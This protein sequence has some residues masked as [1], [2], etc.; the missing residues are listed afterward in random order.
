MVM[1][2][3]ASFVTTEIIS[4]VP[5]DLEIIMDMIDKLYVK[6][7]VMATENLRRWNDEKIKKDEK[8]EKKIKAIIKRNMHGKKNNISK[9]NLFDLVLVMAS[10]P[11]ELIGSIN[12]IMKESIRFL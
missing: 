11:E 9:N 3:V 10:S 4:P 7:E 12:E 2:P 5:S 1:V 8:N 6:L